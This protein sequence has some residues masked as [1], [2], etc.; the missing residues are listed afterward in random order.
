V[1]YTRRIFDAEGA[2]FTEA[3]VKVVQDVLDA[4]L[5]EKV[6]SGDME[7]LEEYKKASASLQKT[8]LQNLKMSEFAEGVLEEVARR[9]KQPVL[10]RKGEYYL[11]MEDVIASDVPQEV[12]EKLD[13]VAEVFANVG[14]SQTT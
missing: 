9:Q 7:Q 5:L 13:R 1:R 3:T 8:L 10:L 12:T 4:R 11:M 6:F 2:L 14:K